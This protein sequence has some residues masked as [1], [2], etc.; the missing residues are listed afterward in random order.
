MGVMNQAKSLTA[1][2]RVLVV[3]FKLT[4]TLRV[5]PIPQLGTIIL[6]DKSKLRSLFR[7]RTSKSAVVYTTIIV[8]EEG[9]P[10]RF[11]QAFQARGD[12]SF[13]T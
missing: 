10:S 7:S 1:K 2:R 8:G 4:S 11:A 9:Q 5:R 3:R 13:E 12:Y 6:A